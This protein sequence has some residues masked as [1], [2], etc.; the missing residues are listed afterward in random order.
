ML[1]KV[2]EPL[3]ILPAAY[4]CVFTTGC[5]NGWLWDC[6][7]LLLMWKQMHILCLNDVGVLSSLDFRCSLLET[8]FPSLIHFSI[9]YLSPVTFIFSNPNANECL[10]CSMWGKSCTGIFY[11]PS[12][13]S[14]RDIRVG[15]AQWL[16][17]V[18]RQ[19][20]QLAFMLM[21]QNIWHKQ[22]QGEELILPHLFRGFSPRFCLWEFW[23]WDPAVCHDWRS[24]HAADTI[25][26]LM[27]RKRKEVGA[28]KW[29]RS[30]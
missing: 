26:L 13:Y 28:M 18:M 10:S 4:G 21:P 30:R 9:G 20:C 22:L 7:V 6:S 8:P 2:D 23:A 24:V 19:M 16:P 5:D 3:C 12:T 27:K 17:I 11:M 14:A 1:A 25:H 29:V 15:Q